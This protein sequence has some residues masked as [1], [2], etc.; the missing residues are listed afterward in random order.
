[1][2][3]AR[4]WL[5]T[6]LRVWTVTQQRPDLPKEHNV[7]ANVQPANLLVLDTETTIDAAQSLTFGS[8]R[9][10]RVSWIGA[11]PRLTCA[12]E[13]LFY[14]DDLGDRDTEG[15]QTLREYVAGYRAATVEGVPSALKLI[16]RTEFVNRVLYQEA[17]KKRSLIVGFNLPFDLSRLAV[18][19]GS[20]R[21]RF[22]GGISLALFTYQTEDGMWKEAH[23][24]R[25][26][27]A[28]K[29]I[30]SK[31]ALKGF[32]RPGALDDIDQIP[33]GAEGG[34]PEEGYMFRG[35]FLDLRTVV[36]ALTDE[37]H[38]LA[39]ACEA[40]GVEAGK[41]EVESHGYISPE[42]IEYNRRD[43]EATAELFVKVMEDYGPHPI[44]LQPT[45]AYS[46]AS[47][48]KAYL[49]AMGIEPRLKRQ[50]DFSPEIL[51]YSMVSYYGGRAECRIRKVPLPVVYLDFLSMYPTVNALMELWR[52]HIAEQ[53]EVEDRTAEI[54]R[55]LE[56]ITLD[57]CF[58]PETWPQLMVIVEVEAEGDVLPIR[59]R[60]D[61]A[62]P[63][64]QI[65]VN[66]LE[67]GQRWHALADVVA[68]KLLTG[69]AP[70][71]LRA[72][73]FV[74][75]GTQS[76]LRPVRLRGEIPVDPVRHDLFNMAVEERQRLKRRSDLSPAEKARHDFLKV[77]ANATS[78]GITAEL[79]RRE[80]PKDKTEKVGVYGLDE[81]FEVR[82][83]APEDPGEFCFPP[84]AACITSSARLM[85]AMLERRVADLGGIHVLCDTDSMAIVATEDG[86]LVPCPG[87]HL[88]SAVGR[89]CVLAL[90]GTR[91]S[92]SASASR[93]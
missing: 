11:N 43:V 87:G 86:G 73:A 24:Y 22:Q 53:I 19:W 81:P 12:E 91:S 41:L 30:D 8:Y 42:Y 72:L 71:I 34:K 6:A 90:S 23:L 84:L 36:Y 54:R 15:L 17:F 62:V 93:R 80:L 60:Y 70:R 1:M 31:R 83:S 58:R 52:F 37:G 77:F 25:P 59:A 55:L 10:Y 88:R 21:G 63:S 5:E 35:H 82:T 26:R 66:V 32:I 61:P 20:A 51:G 18:G 28:I 64:W 89:D 67:A 29:H 69:K 79:I 40:Y 14:A 50:A 33:E 9:Y 65:G 39:S 47:I 92:R 85:L 38:S 4:D 76:G 48:G 44:S 75:T 46:P 13:G 2:V 57:D 68:S 3:M 16:S 74:P 78:Y 49:R 45:K 56:G 27:V 7:R